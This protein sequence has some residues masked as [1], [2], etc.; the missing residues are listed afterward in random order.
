MADRLPRSSAP[1]S[2][3]AMP[4]QSRPVR[5]LANCEEAGL[6]ISACH[7]PVPTILVRRVAASGHLAPPHERSQL[8][9]GFITDM[10]PDSS[11]EGLVRGAHRR[12]RDN[13]R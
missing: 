11:T 7:G 8:P 2:V 13:N 12:R 6:T 5:S 9:H 3:S 10:Q 1:P 4:P